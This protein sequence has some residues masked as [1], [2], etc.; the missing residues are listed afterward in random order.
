MESKS[1]TISTIPFKEEDEFNTKP[2]TTLKTKPYLLLL[3]IQVITFSY[4][5]IL[6]NDRFFIFFLIV[7]ILIFLANLTLF[8]LHLWKSKGEGTSTN[9]NTLVNNSNILNDISQFYLLFFISFYL[10]FALSLQLVIGFYMLSSNKDWDSNYHFWPLIFLVHYLHCKVIR[11]ADKYSPLRT[12]EIL[13]SEEL[14]YDYL[15]LS[16]LILIT[17]QSILLNNSPSIIIIFSLSI[18]FNILVSFK[19]I[20]LTLIHFPYTFTNLWR[21]LGLTKNDSGNYNLEGFVVILKR[22]FNN[23]SSLVNFVG[24][25]GRIV[26]LALYRPEIEEIPLCVIV[27]MLLKNFVVSIKWLLQI[28]NRLNYDQNDTPNTPNNPSKTME[29]SIDDL[30]KNEA[31]NDIQGEKLSKISFL[32][33]KLSVKTVFHV[34][35]FLSRLSYFLF[36]GITQTLLHLMLENGSNQA[37]T[38]ILTISYIFLCIEVINNTAHAII[39]YQKADFLSDLS[40][41]RFFYWGIVVTILCFVGRI[42][43]GMLVIIEGENDNTIEIKVLRYIFIVIYIVWY[44]KGKTSFW[45]FAV[46]IGD[47]NFLN[48]L[49][50]NENMGINLLRFENVELE[51]LF[52]FI[53]CFSFFLHG[54][55]NSNLRYLAILGCLFEYINGVVYMML[56]IFIYVFASNQEESLVKRIKQQTKQFRLFINTIGIL[57]RL[58]LKKREYSYVFISKHLIQIV[59]SLDYI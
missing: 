51:M 8:T 32:F 12:L 42:C 53:S 3:S 31:L 27:I 11:T 9:D 43:I 46:Y 38:T 20:I 1:P 47:S 40:E 16:T 25:V 45:F 14:C 24:L 21:F 19:V 48:D 26:L 22:K 34:S 6:T 55:E 10:C 58:V 54:Y 41:E 13:I 57:G 2:L 59:I 35:H 39:V 15:D 29:D 52:D 7:F 44:L 30:A 4:L 37:Y 56:G 36:I 17:N 28:R 33:S 5:L 18:C 49:K 50:Y 23:I